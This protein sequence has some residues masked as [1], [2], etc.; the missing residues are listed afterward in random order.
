LIPKSVVFL[1]R[2]IPIGGANSMKQWVTQ[3]QGHSQKTIS[4]VGFGFQKFSIV[5]CLFLCISRFY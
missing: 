4:G 3:E 1:I 2:T 5:F